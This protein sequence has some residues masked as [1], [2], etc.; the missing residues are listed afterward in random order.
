M[1]IVQRRHKE[2]CKMLRRRNEARE[3]FGADFVRL[4]SYCW[5][6]HRDDRL[7]PRAEFFHFCERHFKNAVQRALPAGVC[8]CDNLS[9]CIGK[10]HDAA[11][12]PGDAKTKAARRGDEAI[13]TRSLRGR[14]D[15]VEDQSLG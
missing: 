10:K 14:K 2:A 13:A 11:V 8:G 1:A 12:G 6:E 4:R 7:P 3:E 9:V 5:A 15:L